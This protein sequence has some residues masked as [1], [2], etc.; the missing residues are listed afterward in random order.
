MLSVTQA[1]KNDSNNKLCIFIFFM[2]CADLY[3]MQKVGPFSA[4]LRTMLQLSYYYNFQWHLAFFKSILRELR[5][6]DQ[7]NPVF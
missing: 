1:Q 7:I 6:T 5:P 3:P 2:Q 4:H